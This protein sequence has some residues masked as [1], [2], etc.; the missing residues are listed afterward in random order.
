MWKTAMNG[1]KNSNRYVKGMYI[2]GGIVTPLAGYSTFIQEYER[3][4]YTEEKKEFD[5]FWNQTLRAT[6]CAGK[7]AERALHVAIGYPLNQVASTQTG[8]HVLH[9][10][11]TT[12]VS[13]AVGVFVGGMCAATWPVSVPLGGLYLAEDQFGIKLC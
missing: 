7:I 4:P 12:G 10:I 9:I 3:G 13:A 1:F 2:V 6:S 8:A 11:G 5:H